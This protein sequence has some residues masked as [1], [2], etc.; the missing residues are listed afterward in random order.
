MKDLQRKI[1]YK[2][3]I[4]DESK[5]HTVWEREPTR[6][7]NLLSPSDYDGFLGKN[8]TRLWPNVNQVHVVNGRIEMADANFVGTMYFDKI[9][10]TDIWLGP[11]PQ[12]PDD[13]ELLIQA[14][15]TGVL[16]VQTYGD[17]NF[18][19]VNQQL[20]MKSYAERGISAVHF[21]IE[22]F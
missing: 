9:G 10:N 6:E 12:T 3:S 14:G 8:M 16:N 15:V 7:L 2:Y 18:R 21:P 5:Q 17:L 19:G 4:Y 13:I 20:M 1:K 22:D 11:Y